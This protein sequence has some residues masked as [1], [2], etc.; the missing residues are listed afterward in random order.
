MFNVPLSIPSAYNA[1]SSKIYR[2]ITGPRGGKKW[3][4]IDTIFASGVYLPDA[5]FD[6]GEYK[7]TQWVNG[8]PCIIHHFE[9]KDN[10]KVIGLMQEDY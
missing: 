10:G 5:S 6:A 3:V 9:V 1:G 2:L 7:I 8:W 4:H